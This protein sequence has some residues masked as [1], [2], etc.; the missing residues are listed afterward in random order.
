MNSKVMEI[1]S[2]KLKEL[3]K[4]KKLS[5]TDLA[6]GIGV[7]PMAISRWERKIQI[8]NIEMLDLIAKY[9][10]ETPNYLLGYED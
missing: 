9:F 5:L 7:T 3:R 8:P 4:D 6:N 1:F 2:E 10:N